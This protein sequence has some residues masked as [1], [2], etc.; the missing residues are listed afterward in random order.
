MPPT[1]TIRT[2]EPGDYDQIIAQLDAWWAGRQMALML[3]RLFFTHFR[4]WTF[5]AEQEGAVVGF[6][7]AFRS[8]TDPDQVYCHFIGVDPRCRGQG[9]GQALYQRLLA[10]ATERGCREA[11]AVTAPMNRDSIA[12][13]QGLGF[14]PIPGPAASGGTPFSPSYDGPGEDRVRFV[15]ALDQLTGHSPALPD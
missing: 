7:V 13:H 12:F 6:L 9:F 3:P 1:T 5:V 11:L 2:A 4:P 10:D 15:R 14:V 8:Q